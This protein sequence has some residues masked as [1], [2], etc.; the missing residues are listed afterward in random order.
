VEHNKLGSAGVSTRSTNLARVLT[1]LHREGSR[2]R[3]QLTRETGLNRSTIGDLVGE[4]SQSGL[5]I[6]TLPDE[7]GAVGRPSPLVAAGSRV[8]VLTAN[9]DVDSVTVGLVGLGGVV[10]KR[11][12]YPTPGIPSPQDAVNLIAAVVAGMR[13][14]LDDRYDI[15]GIGVAV[16]G[17]VNQAEGIVTHAPHLGWRDEALGA[18]VTDAVG[19]PCRLANDATAGTVAESRFGAGRGLSDFI[20]LN[21]SASGI[22]G[23]AV[24]GGRPLVGADGYAGEFGH[25]VVNPDGDRCHCGRTGCLQTEVDRT[26]LLAALGAG[27]EAAENLSDLLA[28]DSKNPA[29]HAEVR[30]QIGW[31]AIAL[32]DA[33]HVL[34]PT[35]VLLGG[36]LAS[37][38]QVG[39]AELITAVRARGFRAL[40]DRVRISS[41]WLGPD[42]LTIG[43]A[44]LWFDDLLADPHRFIRAGWTA[45]G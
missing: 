37:L 31:L 11:V 1:L 36:F 23:G 30:R 6:E 13:P 39:S 33:I 20:Y 2:S 42:L 15:V 22:G 24:V 18:R 5:V 29:V 27:P 41:A 4:L 32:T 17:L 14:E 26:R 45:T 7:V 34:N 16:P 38:N 44:E 19:Y 12:R 43:A 9:P 10:H 8:A 40:T 35:A 3:A 28:A 21:G 25:T